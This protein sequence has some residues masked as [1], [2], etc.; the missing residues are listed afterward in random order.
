MHKETI[1]SEF[2]KFYFKVALL[3][4]N[5]SKGAK[6]C[7]VNKKSIPTAT[8]KKVEGPHRTTNNS[9]QTIATFIFIYFYLK[10]NKTINLIL[11][12]LAVVTNI[13]SFGFP[14]I[15]FV[16]YLLF[17]A[18]A[19][20]RHHP[21][22]ALSPPLSQRGRKNAANLAGSPGQSVFRRCF[23]FSAY[24][25]ICVHF[26]LLGAE[27]TMACLHRTW[28]GVLCIIFYLK[29]PAKTSKTSVKTT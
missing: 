6:M 2:W 4:S 16:L 27:Q 24:F 17:G 8:E 20:K 9:L 13:R 5:R 22:L 28:F 23:Y 10:S 7:Q 3:F 19:V 14:S 25:L 18:V 15:F 29:P 21:T 26:Y 12:V 11:L 1:Y